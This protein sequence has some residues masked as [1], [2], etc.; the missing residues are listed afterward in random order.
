MASLK[1]VANGLEYSYKEPSTNVNGSPLIDLDHT[2]IFV[3]VG[4][5]P[6]K[7]MDVPASSPNGGGDVVQILQNPFSE[8]Q[9]GTVTAFSIAVDDNGNQAVKGGE[10]T[11]DVDFLAPSPTL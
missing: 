5:G 2:E 6:A 10:A 11:A 1:Q 3:D 7:V 8:G 9:E 4:A